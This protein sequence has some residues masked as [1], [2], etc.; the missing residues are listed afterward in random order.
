MKVGY[1]TIITDCSIGDGTVIWHH[2]NLYQCRI[3]R[4]C[5]IGS[6]VEIGKGVS[7]GDNC[8]IEAHSFIPPG[9]TIGDN[10][11]VGPHVV[12]TNDLYPR[13]M[14]AW[15]INPTIVQDNVS[16][17]AN[18]TVLSGITLGEGCM[19]GAGSIVVDSILPKVVVIGVKATPRRS[20]H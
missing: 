6:F 8:K 19:I 7:I 4:N 1:G 10:V 2:C 20:I 9:V 12:F 14:G 18:S 11:F 3:G 16:I 15:K 13:A 17:G 5:T